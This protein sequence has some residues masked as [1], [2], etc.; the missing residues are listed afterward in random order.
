MKH[1]ATFLLLGCLSLGLWAQ[2]V[3]IKLMTYNLMFYKAPSTPC[4]HSRSGAQ[5][6][7]DLKT[8]VQYAQPDILS[9]VEMG[10]NPINP[11]VITSNIL[12]TDG[13][14]HY[15]SANY[16]SSPFSSLANMLFYNEDKL[17]LHSQSTV[18][19]DPSNVPLI[20]LVDFYRL[21]VKDA[22]HGEPGVDTTW[23]SVGVVHF[24]AG[25]S[26]SDRTEREKAAQAIMN[27][28]DNQIGDANVVLTGDLNMRSSSEA[29]YQTMVN[30]SDPT[31][32]LE[33]PIQRSGN[34]NNNS[35]FA[36]EHT[37][38]THSSSQGCFAGGGMDDR[39]DQ[40]LVSSS[41]MSG[42]A[43]LLYQRYNALG[44][45]GGSF[46]GPLNRNTNFE[47]NATVANALYNF[48]D[49]LPVIMEMN[50][51]VSGIGLE[52]YHYWEQNLEVVNPFSEQLELQ[53]PE[54]PRR[55]MQ[56]R[57]YN[58]A[59]QT[60]LEGTWPAGPRRQNWSMDT[61]GLAEGIYL[62]R[63]QQANGGASIT[64]K[65]IKKG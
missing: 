47:V 65:I 23:L 44:Q 34:W 52:E 42:N 59:G 10:S 46:N 27:H 22:G 49:H 5:R 20:R 58:L 55:P 28:I 32:R 54:G 38:S 8:I 48:S 7:S 61:Q 6:D 13:V 29:A 9:V 25:S 56:V 37:Q 3:P 17:V 12:N 2:S 11:P 41:L 24:K 62:L 18:E 4:N 60:I 19:M 33:D 30:Y 16:T 45:D 43:D 1:Y 40:I 26:S 57:L 51:Q 35:N 14:S 63:M 36:T 64:R 15:Q 50:A 39:F 31:A 53:L 21:Y